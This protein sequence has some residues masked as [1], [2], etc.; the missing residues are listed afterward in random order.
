MATHIPEN[1]RKHHRSRR[2]KHPD[3]TCHRYESGSARTYLS[4]SAHSHYDFS[5]ADDPS[6]PSRVKTTTASRRKPSPPLGRYPQLALYGQSGSTERSTTPITTITIVFISFLPCSHIH[7]TFDHSVP[8]RFTGTHSCR[9]TVAH[10]SY[11]WPV[12]PASPASVKST[13]LSL[14]KSRPRSSQQQQP[15]RQPLLAGI[16]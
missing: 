12:R 1:L 4:T 13:C 11:A 8:K 9:F 5:A 16:K 14:V 2:G 3:G 15:P 6:R 7:R 10:A